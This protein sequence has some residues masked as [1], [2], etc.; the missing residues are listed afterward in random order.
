MQ[1]ELSPG[2]VV[3]QFDFL[4]LVVFMVAVGYAT[5]VLLVADFA[6][7][8]YALGPEVTRRIVHLFAGGAIWTVPYYSHPWVAT[9]VAFLFVVLLAFANTE[10]FGRF[11]KAMARPEDLEQGSVRGPFWY[12]VSI[13][14]LTGLFTF[15]GNE[16]VYFIAGAAIHMMMFGDGMAAPIGMR[17]GSAHTRVILGSRRS[18][19]GSLALFI[20][21]FLGSLLA[22]WFF[23]VLNYGSLIHEGSIM[24]L[25][26]TVLALVGATSATLIEL[27]SPRGSDN[28][29]LPFLTTLVLLVAAVQLG[30]VVLPA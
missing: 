25:E 5:M 16:A 27:V 20:F 10:R 11:F 1:T 26:M 24:Y 14:T 12:A 18:L 19:H 17:F 28:V 13:T 7:R 30:I 8:R 3:F 2:I 6:R 4:D 29:T 9:A 15:T 21:A 22:F 23:G